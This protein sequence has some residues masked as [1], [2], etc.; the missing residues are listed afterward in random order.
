MNSNRYTVVHFHVYRVRLILDAEGLQRS[1]T[2]MPEEKVVD[3][4]SPWVEECSLFSVS[5]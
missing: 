4:R 3:P 5:L 1:D 2:C